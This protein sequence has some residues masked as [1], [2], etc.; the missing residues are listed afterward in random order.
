VAAIRG[1]GLEL[2]LP[3]HVGRAGDHAVAHHHGCQRASG[4]RVA[5]DDGLVPFLAQDGPYRG[6][7]KSSSARTQTLIHE[8]R[9]FHQLQGKGPFRQ[10]SW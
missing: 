7:S 4:W 2:G 6:R 9:R 10:S 5:A 1:D 3:D 8:I